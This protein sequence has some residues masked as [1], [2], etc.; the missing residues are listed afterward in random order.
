MKAQRIR[1][2]QA[3]ATLQADLPREI[4]VTA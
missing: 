1:A 3:C 2:F 4:A